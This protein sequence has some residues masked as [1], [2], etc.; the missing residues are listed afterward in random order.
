MNEES[1]DIIKNLTEADKKNIA[2]ILKDYVFETKK[3]NLVH[4]LNP[5]TILAFINSVSF[6][7]NVEENELIEVQKEKD[8]V[9]LYKLLS[10]SKLAGK[11]NPKII[12]IYKKN[13]LK[14]NKILKI[15]RGRI[16]HEIL[17][18][19][20]P[21]YKQL[22]KTKNE[23]A[24]II[25]SSCLKKADYNLR[26]HFRLIEMDIFFNENNRYINELTENVLSVETKDRDILECI[27]FS[28]L[29]PEH[30]LSSYFNNFQSWKLFPLKWFV[31]HIPIDQAKTVFYYYR[32]GHDL[33]K[34][35]GDSYIDED[36]KSLLEVLDN[37]YLNLTPLNIVQPFKK[38]IYEIIQCFKEEKFISSLLTLYPVIEGVIWKFSIVLHKKRLQLFT[39][40]S[41]KYLLSID[42]NKLDKTVGSLFNNTS[43]KDL[44][45]INFINYFCDEFYNE[46]NPMLH[47]DN[48]S[49][50]TKEDVIKKIITL[51][52]ILD[53]AIR[54]MTEILHEILTK[55]E[56]GKVIKNK[57]NKT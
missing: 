39:N 30:H 57:V 49:E 54:T 23:K 10:E 13:L 19:Q 47:G 16:K 45:D 31:N 37:P 17:G 15:K 28:I 35:I 43:M 1:F 12:D 38:A 53:L 48:L 36:F 46:R 52:Y 34:I 9:E 11:I 14:L 21:N 2:A 27:A 20:W 7:S 40:N 55:S 56:I 50:I 18:K 32:N 4:K 24:E 51:D 41:Y 26:E 6:L 25:F 33:T 3:E 29:R 8:F 44:L 42:G 22:Y 5:D